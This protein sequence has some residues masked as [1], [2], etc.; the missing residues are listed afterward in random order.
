ML[1]EPLELADILAVGALKKLRQR[2]MRN[3]RW[4]DAP[5]LEIYLRRS[6]LRWA[7]GS[8]VESQRV[9]AQRA[10]KR[11]TSAAK[12]GA[13]DLDTAWASVVTA[14]DRL[15]RAAE[16]IEGHSISARP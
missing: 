3:P 10:L 11:Y 1:E 5:Y 9:E 16:R 15:I 12:R 14:V 4:R 13:D 7:E 6:Y 2:S 8:P